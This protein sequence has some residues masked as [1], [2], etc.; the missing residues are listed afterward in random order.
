MQETLNE[1][2]RAWQNFYMLAG[3]TSASLMGL[4]F[5]AASLAAR[6][7]DVDIATVGA[8]A[9]VTPI[10]IHFSAVLVIAMLFMIP[11][12]T[13]ASL[14]IYLGLGGVAGLAYSSVTGVQLWQHHCERA[15]VKRTD[16]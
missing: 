12:H 4:V 11:T 1:I 6:L 15:R 5:V 3:G 13:T 10:I 9:F 16:W 14:G 2:L 8:R 7:L